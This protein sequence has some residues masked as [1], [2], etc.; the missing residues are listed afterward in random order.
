MNEYHASDGPESN[1]GERV[2]E[3]ASVKQSVFWVFSAKNL[4]F[5]DRHL[6][7]IVAQTPLKTA[8]GPRNACACEALRQPPRRNMLGFFHSLFAPPA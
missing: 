1:G 7:S 6:G 3:A 2:I 8:C 5:F 4:R